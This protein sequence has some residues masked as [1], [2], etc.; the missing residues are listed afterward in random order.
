MLPRRSDMT[1]QFATHLQSHAACI[2]SQDVAR[3]VL[4]VAPACFPARQNQ[5]GLPLQLN[6]KDMRRML[7]AAVQ[8]RRQGRQGG[9]RLA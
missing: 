4:A 3:A 2:H 6:G 9:N 1:T 8:T 7:L 5:E